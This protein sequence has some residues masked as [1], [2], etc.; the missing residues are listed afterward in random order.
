MQNQT[1]SKNKANSSGLSRRDFIKTSAAVSVATAFA[2][3][4]KVFA[5]GSDK[6]RIGLVGCGG[7]G[8][9][10]TISA[11]KS[12]EAVEVTAMGDIFKDRLD[13]SLEKLKKDA[14]DK[15][16]L[17]PDNCFVGF[18]AYKKVIASDVDLVF[19][20]TPPH[21]RPIHL[22]AVIEAGKH[23]FIEK[24]AAT[25]PVGIRS[26]IETSELAKSKGL[27][28]VAG[29]Q[30]RH[31]ASHIEII[32]RIHNGDIGE[33]VGGQCYRLGDELWFKP[34]QPDWTDMEYQLRNWLYYT[35]LSGDHVVEMHI[36]QLDAINWALDSHPV[37]VMAIGGREVRTDPKFGNVYD[38]FAGELE[39]PNGARIAYMGRQID[40]CGYNIF[41][42]VVGTKGE[43]KFDGGNSTIMG[44]NPYK[45]DGPSKNSLFADLITSIRKGEPL[46]EG[47]RMAE[48]TMVAIMIRMSAFT[49][50]TLGWN[51][52]MNASKLDLSPPKYEFGDLAV[53]PV[54]IPGVT[55]LV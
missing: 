14:P 52:A 11:V 35:W 43:A 45:Y 28:I 4:N 33:I 51:W 40:R 25:D 49:G 7:Q 10:D 41:E 55:P 17:T 19:L 31:S 22:K 27:A 39:Y 12:S 29:T 32:R 16:N 36:H 24:P 44:Q 15:L 53:R 42:R 38:H 48:S 20:T 23:A 50:R 37:K 54:A 13:S 34:R 2:G 1:S 9:R 26:V 21:F 30:K 8:T 18:D 3:A 6:V 5:A 46:N 47:R